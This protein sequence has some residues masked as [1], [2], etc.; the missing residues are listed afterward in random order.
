[1]ILARVGIVRVESLCR[2]RRVAILLSAVVA[3]FHADVL[4][5]GAIALP[6]YGMYELSILTVRLFGGPHS[7]GAD[8]EPATAPVETGPGAPPAA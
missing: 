6:L 8:L 5:M 4:T 2:Q 3:A 7:R 1:L